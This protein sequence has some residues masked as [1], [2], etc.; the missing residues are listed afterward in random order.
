MIEVNKTNVFG[1]GESDFNW[2]IGPRYRTNNSWRVFGKD[3]KDCK[4][5]LQKNQYPLKMIS[6]VVKSHL[7]DKIKCRNEKSAQITVSDVEIRYF[8]LRFIGVNSK[9]KQKE[10]HQ[11]C[12]RF[13]K[14]LKV[15][16]IFTS[17]KLG[18]AFPRKTIS[19][20]PPF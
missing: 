17:E 13:Y 7:N 20:W 14:S 2:I 5:I 10:V 18:C 19:N 9:L 16:L 6:H 4:N 15:K 1:R 12:K 8:K 11:L 3:H